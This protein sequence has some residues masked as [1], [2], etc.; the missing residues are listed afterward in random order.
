MVLLRRI[1][2]SL[3]WGMCVLLLLIIPSLCWPCFVFLCCPLFS[4]LHFSV[5][6]HCFYQNFFFI[7]VISC[8]A[9]LF[10]PQSLH[11]L[12]LHFCLLFLWFLSS[13]L[14]LRFL[15][16]LPSILPSFLPILNSTFPNPSILLLP[17]L[18][19]QPLSAALVAPQG[20]RYDGQIAVYGTDLQRKLG[21]SSVFLVGAG[22]IGWDLSLIL[23][24]VMYRV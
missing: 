3:R 22:A 12:L 6:V 24:C 18:V 23:L 16:F 2:Q 17:P 13:F 8:F 14:L 7:W 19:L 11:R 9:H 20:C 15:L 10:S 1:W 4:Y 5:C 21:S